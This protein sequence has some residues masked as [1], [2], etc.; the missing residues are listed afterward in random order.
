MKNVNKAILLLL[1]FG[2]SSVTAQVSQTKILGLPETYEHPYGPHEVKDLASYPCKDG[3]RKQEA[4][5]VYSDRDGNQ[6]Y[7]DQDLKK[8]L[9]KIDFMQKYYVVEDL[10]DKA[11]LHLIKYSR[12]ILKSS[13]K[14]DI[15][16]KAAV[17]M[18]YIKKD[19][20]L[21]WRYSLEDD[22]T[23]FTIKALP[24]HTLDAFLQKKKSSA[25]YDRTKSELP[26]YN[27][28]ALSV[29]NDQT[30]RLFDF[31]YIYKIDAEHNTYLIGRSDVFTASSSSDIM[32]WAPS[33]YIT[34][35]KQRL[36]LEP[37]SKEDAVDDRKT[38]NIKACL[39]ATEKEANTFA[40]SP[41]GVQSLLER[42][43]GTEGYNA[44]MK[45]FPALSTSVDKNIVKT[46]AATD[47]YGQNTGEKIMSI[48]QQSKYNEQFN[49]AARDLRHF[50]IVFVV[51]CS[52]RMQERSQLKELL[53]ALDN[54]NDEFSSDLQNK[55]REYIYKYGAIAYRSYEHKSCSKELDLV[56]TKQPLTEHLDAVQEFLATEIKRETNCDNKATTKAMYD[57]LEKSLEIF[58][59]PNE[60]NIIILIGTSADMSK[61]EATKKAI[62]DGMVKYKASLIAF[63]YFNA[64]G[65]VY[66]R[67]RSQVKAFSQTTARNIT[68]MLKPGFKEEPAYLEDGPAIFKLDLTTSAIPGSI[69]LSSN[70]EMMEASKL[71]EELVGQIRDLQ[72][73][74]EN[75]ITRGSSLIEGVGKKDMD[76][77][78]PVLLL[79]QNSGYNVND[80]EVKKDLSA[81]NFQFFVPCYA[82]VRPKPLK[83]DL[84]RYV[85]LISAQE[86]SN[87][88]NT[89]HAL[90]VGGS[91]SEMK[92]GLENAF[93]KLMEDHFGEKEAKKYFKEKSMD[94]I[95]QMLTGLPSTSLLL[96]QIKPKELQKLSDDKIQTFINRVNDQAEA[97][98]K[99]FNDPTNKYSFL[100]CGDKYYWI[101][102]DDLP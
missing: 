71:R 102:Q 91:S 69:L 49:K 1:V 74:V 33:T 97:L 84:F 79:L 64:N 30:V 61:N 55:D 70:G 26:L 14:L 67:F 87:L 3:K 28:P 4:W 51:E 45:R 35:W 86:L 57:G 54:V 7:A 27:D 31:L 58:N 62:I 78:L 63:Q 16:N 50:N 18:G 100:S 53:S 6:T 10:C 40:A 2:Y 76:P 82:V 32:G 81:T 42:D 99:I 60:T 34:K 83:T 75:V 101:D 66:D 8:P 37:N 52:E 98:K 12:G 29:V 38:Q 65:D 56:A 80:P 93:K 41:V 96:K 24:G 44:Y 90:N 48:E 22:E 13:A 72:S 47:I 9:E 92:D 68:Q 11:V 95:F 20:L 73:G 15:D 88:L 23:N 17:N 21:L 85:I 59:S 39:L 19:K 89:L 5:I 46:L 43:P 25:T 94:E 77:T 36:C